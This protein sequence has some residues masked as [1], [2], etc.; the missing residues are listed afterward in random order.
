MFGWY[1][2]YYYI[3]EEIDSIHIAYFYERSEC[4]DFIDLSSVLIVV[5]SAFCIRLANYSKFDY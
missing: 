1:S 4:R 2:A 3:M 5:S